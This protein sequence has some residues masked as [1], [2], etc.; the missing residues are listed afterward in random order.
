MIK[1][2]D[3]SS[4]REK[5]KPNKDLT[6]TFDEPQDDVTVAYHRDRDEKWEQTKPLL[7]KN[8]DEFNN[9]LKDSWI[10]YIYLYDEEKKKWLWD[11]VDYVNNNIELKDLDKAIKNIDKVAIKS[12]YYFMI[13][14]KA[15]VPFLNSL[16]KTNRQVEFDDWIYNLYDA[17]NWDLAK[18]VDALMDS[19]NMDVGYEIDNYEIRKDNISI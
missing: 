8:I 1:L 18:Q 10:E 11:Y 15:E 13:F 16:I 9:W 19:K 7:N 14:D 5:L 12:G 4:L 17:P 6:H 2:G 3:I